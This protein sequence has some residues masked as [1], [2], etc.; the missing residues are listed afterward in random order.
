MTTSD[1]GSSD[2]E[3]AAIGRQ[4]RR[5]VLGR[6]S[7][8]VLV[9]ASVLLY[10]VSIPLLKAV[11]NQ[12]VHAD[13]LERADA[14]I[15]LAPSLDRVLEAAE[16]YR[17]GYAPVI[18]LTREER[19]PAEQLLLERG[20][21][22]SGEDR[23]RKILHA[24]GVPLEA[25]VILD[26]YVSSTAGEALRFAQWASDHPVRSVLV[27]TSPLH[28]GRS[29][30]AFMKALENFH[31]KVVVHPS[32]LTRFRSDTWWQ[33]RDTLRDGVIEWQR[34]VYY[35]LVELPRLVPPSPARVGSP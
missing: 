11:G 32:T 9:V 14:M 23:R 15:V 24:L 7:V 5:V 18:L 21:V 19:Q 22:E 34:L 35:R 26:D 1:N 27:V 6:R 33:S 17:G 16:L 8:G 12:L 29:R 2:A 25:I 4:R 30:L 20:I 31:V 28:T 3:A 10:V 13:P